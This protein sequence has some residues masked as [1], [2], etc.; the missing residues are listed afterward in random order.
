[1]TVKSP[2]LCTVPCGVV[3]EIFPVVAPLGTVAVILVPAAFTV[4]LAETPLNLTEV[5]PVNFFPKISTFV[6]GGPLVGENDVISAAPV[7]VKLV[8]LVAVPA[9]VVTVILPVVALAGTFTV[10][11]VPALFTLNPGAFTPLKFTEVVPPKFVPLMVTV[12]PTGPEPGENDVI[13]GCEDVPVT[14]KLV[15]LRPAPSAFLT[16]ISP[17]VAPDGTVAV[18]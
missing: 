8:A 9:G 16:L 14:T 5:A 7:T 10:I 13:D 2:V 1:V 3:T 12:V 11:L 6:P 4:K 17:V 15:L 18:I